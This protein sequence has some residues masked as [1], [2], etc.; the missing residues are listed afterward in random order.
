M[1]SL[2][3]N[4]YDKHING[5]I[6]LIYCTHSVNYTCKHVCYDTLLHSVCVP[7]LNDQI[8]QCKKNDN[9]TAL[10]SVLRR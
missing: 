5:V 4:F 6:F 9:G 10:P 3:H 2:L 8:S 7:S 1:I